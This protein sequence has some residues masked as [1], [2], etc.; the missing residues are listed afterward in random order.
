MSCST[1]SGGGSLDASV[2]A[3][4]GSGDCSAII[5]GVICSSGLSWT[6][7]N[8]ITATAAAAASG[9]QCVLTRHHDLGF[10]PGAA[11]TARRA[12]ARIESSSATGGWSRL[13]APTLKRFR[14][15]FRGLPGIARSKRS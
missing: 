9:S 3:P 14:V 15:T 4:C 8:A 6:M 5:V 13:A 12:A 10:L 2:P 11:A 7:P 1:A